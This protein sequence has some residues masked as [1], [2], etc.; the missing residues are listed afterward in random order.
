MRAVVLALV[1][2]AVATA[3]AGEAGPPPSC[4]R[5]NVV[6]VTFDALRADRLGAWGHDRPT[7]PAL[8]DLAAR[9]TVFTSCISQSATT[10]SAVPAL[11][12]GKFPVTDRLLVGLALKP[13][14]PTLAT[15][16]R[17]AG[18]RTLAV[19]AHDYARCAYSG[20]AGFDVR[21]DAFPVP[22]PADATAA[23]VVRL[24]D[25]DAR[26]PFF[27]W[28]HLRQP[29]APYDVAQADFR[30]MLVPPVAGP[31]YF[32][33]DV[34][35]P[36]FHQV[37]ARLTEHYR[38]AGEPAVAMRV[39]GGRRMEVTA[40]VVRQLAALY[41]ANVLAGDRA[42][43]TILAA[44][45]RRG[46]QGRTVVVV[47]ADHAESLGEHGWFG[48]NRLWHGMLHTPLVVHVPGRA[49]GRVDAP[50]MNVDV[51]PTVAALVGARLG[52][53]VRGRDLFATPPDPV[54]QYAEYEDE[55]VVIADGLKLRMRRGWARGLYDLRRDP[56][57]STDLV[58]ARPEAVLRLR[59]LG[60]ALR[61]RSLARPDAAPP[62]DIF[63]RLRELGYVEGD[64][65]AED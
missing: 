32:T 15:V 10:V 33:P 19:I 9:S 46:L 26:P 62:T 17:E 55:Y 7:S 36:Q 11:L 34:A 40:S 35:R 20:C 31:D 25:G 54:V 59:R 50:T 49:P 39:T 47:A 48:H 27:L 12:T 44:I 45:D 58:A 41:D 14:E 2:A 60:D 56:G 51:L 22:E 13:D 4:P 1:V 52:H 28:V 37:L 65:A 64:P 16:L 23:R 24:L 57:E 18:Y 38:A 3:A 63:R 5:C 30:T 8:D 21:D 53:T 42:L 61:R 43:A 29:H 6:L